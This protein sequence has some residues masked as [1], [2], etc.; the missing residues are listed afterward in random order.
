METKRALT[1]WRCTCEKI[2]NG[3]MATGRRLLYVVFSEVGI[4]GSP[5]SSV[6]MVLCKAEYEY[7]IQSKHGDIVTYLSWLDAISTWFTIR[8][9]GRLDHIIQIAGVIVQRHLIAQSIQLGLQIIV[10]D[11]GH[12]ISAS[13]RLLH[14]I[15][16]LQHVGHVVLHVLCW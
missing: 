15:G 14:L 11:I 7:L 13:H 4:L 2:W 12:A 5:N 1:L 16:L 6:S 3:A 8:R 9:F 10:I